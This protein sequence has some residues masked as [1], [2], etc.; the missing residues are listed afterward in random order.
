[1]TIFLPHTYDILK[2]VASLADLLH[3]RQRAHWRRDAETWK[4]TGRRDLPL[5]RPLERLFRAMSTATDLLLLFPNAGSVVTWSS[6]VTATIAPVG[7]WSMRATSGTNEP[8]R[9]T[10]GAAL[11]MTIT[12]ATLG[13]VGKLGANEAALCDGANTRYQ[14]PNNAAL[15]ALT[16]WEWVFLVNPSSAGEGNNGTFFYW[17]SGAGGDPFLRYSSSATVLRLTVW[18]ASNVDTLTMTALANGAW[19]LLFAAYDNAGDRKGH[20][21]KGVSGA[22]SEF[23]Y[24]A[25]PAL[26]GNYVAPADPLNLFNAT[27]QTTTFA[28]LADEALIVSGNLVTA[29]TR[30]QLAI[31]SGV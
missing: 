28:G 6:Y 30:T 9:G 10:G 4:D 11:D 31:L 1:M 23:A 12:S 20:L 19:Q 17:G 18:A 22:V 26:T 21:Y 2:P 24:S 13:Q 3:P 7:W 29:T 27:I 14:T 5:P 16:T 8:N 15:A 25:Q